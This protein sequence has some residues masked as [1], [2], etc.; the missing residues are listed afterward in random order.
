MPSFSH[1]KSTG[2]WYLMVVVAA[3]A[4]GASVGVKRA[5]HLAR[6]VEF[7]AIKCAPSLIRQLRY[8]GPDDDNPDFGNHAPIVLWQ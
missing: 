4:A 6:D 2:K 7:A 3:A 8:S 5:H 1:L